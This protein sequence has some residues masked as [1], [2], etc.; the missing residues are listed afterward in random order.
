MRRTANKRA[1]RNVPTKNKS[2]SFSFLKRFKFWFAG[3]LLLSVFFSSMVFKGDQFDPVTFCSKDGFGKVV[4][5]VDTTDELSESQKVRLKIEL[6]TISE[7]SQKRTQPILR[8]GDKLTLYFLMPEGNMPKKVFAMCNPGDVNNRNWLASLSESEKLAQLKWLE[9]AESS[10]D[11]LNE[12]IARTGPVATSPIYEA[13]QY[14]RAAEFPPEALIDDAQNA[15]LIIWSDLIQN[16]SNL[17][18]FKETNDSR[19]FFRSNPL[20]LSGV[21]VSVTHLIS[22]K[23]KSHQTNELVLWWREILALSRANQPLQYVAQP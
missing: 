6:E 2:N 8:R 22:Q 21:D 13:L 5:L 16:S 15:R 18:F 14:I 20:D 17:N 4:L 23:Y 19:E 11:Q 1:S 10:L 3:A 7:T 12:A 9:F